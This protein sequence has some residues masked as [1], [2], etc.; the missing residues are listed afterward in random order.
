MMIPNAPQS[1]PS[2]TESGATMK[3]VKLSVVVN[4]SDNS[5]RPS[6]TFLHAHIGRLPF[7]IDGIVGPPTRR[8]AGGGKGHHLLSSHRAGRGWRWLARRTGMRTLEEQDR[9]ALIRHWRREGTQVVLAEYGP[10][11]LAVMDAMEQYLRRFAAMT[12]RAYARDE[13][14]IKSF[15]QS[16]DSLPDPRLPEGW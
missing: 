4:K 7:D 6:E 11:S 3:D 1:N 12:L 8:R 9:S 13:A 16:I 10:T 5:L 2:S 14:L 15:S